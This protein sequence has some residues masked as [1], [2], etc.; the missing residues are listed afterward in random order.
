[1]SATLLSGTVVVM[2]GHCTFAVG[3]DS[4]STTTE[5]DRFTAA[6]GNGTDGNDLRFSL[7]ED[8]DHW[9]GWPATLDEDGNLI[10]RR[11]RPATKLAATSSTATRFG[12]APPRFRLPSTTIARSTPT[13][14]ASSS[15]T[16]PNDLAF[17]AAHG[18]TP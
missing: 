4:V 17:R 5:D 8:D 1:M 13:M 10:F 6:D 15:S 11:S 3:L 9:D 18:I 2:A 14:S 7:N 12:S 16:R